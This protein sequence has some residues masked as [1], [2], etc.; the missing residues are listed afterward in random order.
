LVITQGHCL[1]RFRKCSLAGRKYVQEAGLEIQNPVHFWLVVDT[2]A[3][4][5]LLQSQ[6]SPQRQV[7]VP[8]KL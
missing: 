4:C 8:L 2:E 5:F 7:L 1:E 6:A 3:L